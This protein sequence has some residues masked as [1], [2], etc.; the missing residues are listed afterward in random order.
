MY[1]FKSMLVNDVQLQF[2]SFDGVSNISLA[3]PI[4]LQMRNVTIHNSQSVGS[5]IFY[6]SFIYERLTTSIENCTFSA[7]NASTEPIISLHQ[8]AASFSLT[9]CSFW[10]NKGIIAQ[11]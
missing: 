7:I 1:L 2:L 11:I 3:N 10:K 6:K 9:N 5:I 4:L 8:S